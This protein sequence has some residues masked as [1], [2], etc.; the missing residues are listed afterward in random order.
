MK[1]LLYLC[2]LFLVLA[3]ADLP[4]GYY[5]F[6]RIIVFISAI[7]VIYREYEGEITGWVLAFG[8]IA[9]LF[10]PLIPIYLHDRSIWAIIDITAAI[11]FAV[12]GSKLKNLTL[13]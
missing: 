6:L 13:S 9:I 12:K 10:N 11:L 1:I 3:M 5:M 8:I 7:L 2:S 4:I